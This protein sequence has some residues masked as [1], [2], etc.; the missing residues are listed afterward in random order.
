MQKHFQEYDTLSF[1]H[2]KTIDSVLSMA[3]VTFKNINT[4]FEKFLKALRIDE[5]EIG[6]L[7]NKIL[8]LQRKIENHNLKE[9]LQNEFDQLE[10]KKIL[11]NEDFSKKLQKMR[12]TT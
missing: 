1:A 2:I 4:N 11:L 10:Q 3:K 6:N 8:N 7:S 9:S 12:E 5:D